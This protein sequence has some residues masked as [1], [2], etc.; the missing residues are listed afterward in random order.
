MDSRGR[1]IRDGHKARSLKA[2]LGLCL[3]PALAL[4]GCSDQTVQQTS[5]PLKPGDYAAILPYQTSDTRAKHIG[6]IS[7]I[8]IRTQLEQGLMDISKDYFDP[9]NHAYV[10][11]KYLDYDELDASDGSRGLLGTLRDDNPNGLN[12][13]ADEDFDT[14]NGIVKGPILVADLYELDFFSGN[15]LD[16]IAIGLAVTDA[17]E[18]DGVRH[19]ITPERLRDFV[20]A[21]GTKIVSYMR[22]RFNDVTPNIPILVAA[23]ELNTDE[24]DSSKGGYVY[25]EYFDGTRTTD[26]TISEEYMLVPSTAFT[27]AQPEMAAQFEIFRADVSRILSDTTYT[28]GE[29]KIQ[30][31]LVQKLTLTITAHGKTVGEILAVIQ[32]VREYLSI[33]ESENCAYKVIIKNNGDICALMD[34]EPDSKSV[35]VLT[36][37]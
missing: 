22:E 21:S 14:G 13:G 29:A 30:D 35:Q 11:H 7:D 28:T 5:K 32:S 24:N 17:V 8:D 31:G 25:A 4:A 23:Y 19:E 36:T 33:F 16:G 18:Q 37:Y 12:P 27:Q 9:S 26:K 2:F 6:L 20:Q 15:A 3:V 34:R 1:V 10:N